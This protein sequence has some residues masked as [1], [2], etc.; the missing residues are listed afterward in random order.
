MKREDLLTYKELVPI[1]DKKDAVQAANFIRNNPDKFQIVKYPSSKTAYV[2]KADV[3][4]YF[5][6]PIKAN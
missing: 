3:D 4:N 6:N 1:L 2:V 5:A